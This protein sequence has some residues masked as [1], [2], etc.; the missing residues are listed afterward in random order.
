MPYDLN[1]LPS[2]FLTSTF[3]GYEA[4]VCGAEYQ[5]IY[6]NVAIDD[7]V[8]CAICKVTPA[9]TSMMVTAKLTCPQNWTLQY[10]GYLGAGHFGD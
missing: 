6:K 4:Y 8:P 2:D 1:S 10:H 9:T 5:F 3:S 7:D